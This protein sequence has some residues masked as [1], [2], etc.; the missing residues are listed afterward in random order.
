MSDRHGDDTD[1]APIRAG[2]VPPD[3]GGGRRTVEPDPSGA[4]ARRRLAGPR[5]RP[6]GRAVVGGLLVALAMVI[7]F[8]AASHPPGRPRA[9]VVV[10]RRAVLLGSR[11]QAADLAIERVDLPAPLAGQTYGSIDQAVGLV[12]LGPL[13]PGDLLQH[14]TVARAEV[15][16]G[17]HELSFAV[18]RDQALDGDLVPGQTV[19]LLATYGTGQSAETVV[20]ARQVR[21]IDV[22]DHSQTSLASTG[23]LVVTVALATDAQVLAATHASQVGAVTLAR[24]DGSGSGQASSPPD[25]YTF[26]A[27]TSAT[28]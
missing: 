24:S 7:T 4:G 19:D 10:V 21:L 9:T 13:Q 2:G 23:K 11:L 18:D 27:T 28:G 15:A 25:S 14:S 17:L 6:S 20:V 1:A 5:A 22:D 26:P 12:T 8:A 16:P 3:E